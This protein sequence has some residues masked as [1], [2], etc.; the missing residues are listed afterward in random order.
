[1]LM[2]C[3]IKPIRAVLVLNLCIMMYHMYSSRNCAIVLPSYHHCKSLN[4]HATCIYASYLYLH[5]E[6]QTPKSFYLY[7]LM[8]HY[9]GQFLKFKG[10]VPVGYILI[11]MNHMSYIFVVPIQVYI[12]LI[13]NISQGSTFIYFFLNFNDVK[14]TDILIKWLCCYFFIV[15]LFK[16]FI[17]LNNII[18]L[19]N[20]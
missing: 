20:L 9:T 2:F 5:T 18:C 10:R 19:V 4:Q 8:C 14:L 11:Y 15:K 12:F 13:L 17:K 16:M 1:M 6:F 7:F 3:D